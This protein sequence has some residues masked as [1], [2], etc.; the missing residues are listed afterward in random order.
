MF[1]P[2]VFCLQQLTFGRTAQLDASLSRSL[3][4]LPHFQHTT[5]PTAP[6]LTLTRETIVLGRDLDHRRDGGVIMITTMSLRPR[7][8]CLM[9]L[10]LSQGLVLASGV[11]RSNGSRCGSSSDALTPTTRMPMATGLQVKL[12]EFRTGKTPKAGNLPHP[13]CRIRCHQS[14]RSSL[15]SFRHL[16]V[17]RTRQAPAGKRLEDHC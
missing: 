4:N 6:S 2:S 14:R 13:G 9:L 15:V 1:V 17:L 12:N 7:P 10:R 11:K 8:T 5:L 16:E 3:L